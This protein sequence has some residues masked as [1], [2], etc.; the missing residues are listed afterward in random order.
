VQKYHPDLLYFDWWIGQPSFRE[1]VSRFAAF[2]YNQAA[3]KDT[4]VVINYKDHAFPEGSAIFDVERGQLTEIQSRPWQTDT[5]ISNA[6]WGYLPNDSYKSPEFIIHLL[7]DVVSKNGNL[8]LNITPRPDGTIPEQEQHILREVGR[9]LKVNGEAI[10]G[11]RPWKRFG[12]GPTA[13]AGGA[14]HDADT[15][16]YTS[17]DFRFAI[18]G[19]I[20]F[21]IELDWPADGRVTIHSL[22]SDSLGSQKI[23]NVS[24][25]GSAEKII[26]QQQPDGLH[27][28]LPQ[29]PLGQYAYAF[30][31]P[32]ETK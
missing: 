19:S 32:I 25:L 9:W 22:G 20:L 17:G 14:F 12:E 27:L 30:R 31:I 16:P 8:L 24:L 28:Q 4:R 29:Q 15:K 11:T 23:Q 10:Y 6:S 26:W 5:S 18:K 7:A 1:H 2:Y 3:K 13:I 21:A